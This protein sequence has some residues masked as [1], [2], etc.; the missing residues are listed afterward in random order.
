MFWK[1]FGIQVWVFTICNKQ[2]IFI[3]LLHFLL[4]ISFLYTSKHNSSELKH[5]YNPNLLYM[6]QDSYA[7]HFMKVTQEISN[8]WEHNQN[9]ETIFKMLL[10]LTF[11]FWTS[12]L[13]A[14]HCLLPDISKLLWE[15]D[16]NT[17]E[18]ILTTKRKRNPSLHDPWQKVASTLGLN[19]GKMEKHLYFQEGYNI[20]LT[21]V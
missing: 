7:A 18:E 10:I 2:K 20:D 15:S 16:W 14:G 8:S 17:H 6:G 12:Q 19:S 13:T 21:S 5:K 4:V 9:S 1:I 11:L 3:L